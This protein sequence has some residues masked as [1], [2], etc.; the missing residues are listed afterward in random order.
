MTRR[1]S[2]AVRGNEIAVIFQE[3]MT[4]LNPV[5]T[6][7]FQI[8]ET[9]RLH[10]DDVARRRPGPA[11]SSCSSWSRCPD[12][13]RRFDAYPHQLSGGQRQRAM[14]AQSL[15]CDP[16]AAHRRR[17]DHGA[18][19]HRAG[20]RSSSSCATCATRVDAGDR[21]DHPRHGRGRRPGRPDRRD[22]ARPDRRDRHRATRSSTT[23]STR[24]PRSCWPPCRTSATRRA[25]STS[26]RPRR[27]NADS[28]GERARASTPLP[29]PS[30]A[31]TRS[32]DAEDVVI[33][34]P[35]RGRSP[36]FRA[37]DGVNLTIDPGEV[38]GLVGESG[39]GKTTIGR[40][41]VGPAA[42]RGRHARGRRL[43]H[44]R[45]DAQGPPAAARARSASSSRT[46]RPR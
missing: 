2:R 16:Q 10:F 30:P 42:G 39:S 12:P 45:R 46:R 23:R 38:V 1:S 18:R 7:G 43:R 9:L 24:T 41:A 27:G 11:R 26:R 35:K 15:A 40:A 3:P 13:E 28:A 33:E 37:V 34:Y 25:E 20:A 32:L 22:A 44:G 5:Y 31:A 17:A 21:P 4:A 8:V 36:A 6:V 29:A 19:R 14:I